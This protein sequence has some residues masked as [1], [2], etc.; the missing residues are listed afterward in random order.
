MAKIRTQFICQ[1]CGASYPKWTGK[2]D[3][4][5]EWN[6]LVEQAPVSQGKSAVA[7][8]ASSGHV[9]TPR[10]MQ[11]IEIEE[12]A[13]RMTTGYSDLDAVL[14]GGILPGGV[15]LMAG[16]PGIGKSTLLLQVASEVGKT[17]A[18]LH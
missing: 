15:M 18:V 10:T 16:Q 13:R 11:S 14:G 9:L 7:R 1:N 17:D 2:C 12:T 6:T 4:C 5:G 3:N 8:S